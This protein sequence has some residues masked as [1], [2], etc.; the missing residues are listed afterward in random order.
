MVMT[1][2]EGRVKPE[3]V[4]KLKEAYQKMVGGNMPSQVKEGFLVQSKNEPELWRLVG[5]WPSREVFEE[6]RRSV[7]TPAGIQMFR[8]AGVEPKLELFEVIEYAQ[9]TAKAA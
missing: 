7:T 9:R 1:I 4:G 8:E 5:I 2:S 3:K 6:Y